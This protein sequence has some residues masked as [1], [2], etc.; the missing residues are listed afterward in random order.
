LQGTR[1]TLDVWINVNN[2]SEED[3]VVYALRGEGVMPAPFDLSEFCD[4]KEGG[5]GIAFAIYSL[6]G[7]QRIQES[8]IIDYSGF[9]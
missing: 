5:T 4:L 8:E 2:D 1:G 9:I 6:D 7:K 3:I